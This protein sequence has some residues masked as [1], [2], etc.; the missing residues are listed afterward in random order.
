MK[1]LMVAPEP[2]FE[3]RGTPFSVVGR[4]KTLSD[5][6]YDI[7][8]V[9]YP[10][11]EEISFP[12]LNINRVSHIPGVKKIKI[13]PSL[14][15][16]PFDFLLMMKTFWKLMTRKYDLLHTHEEAGFWGVIFAKW[17]RVPHLYD[18][19]SSLPQ[20]LTNFKFTKSKFWIGL[21][22]FM[23]KWV[24]KD[25]AGVITICPDL[26][27]YVNK[28]TPETKSV[29]IENVID[30][31]M[32]FGSVDHSEMIKETY[33]LEGKTVFLYTG[34]FEPYQGLDLLL[35][36]A[37]HVVPHVREPRFLI[38][39]GHPDQVVE[40]EKKI[41]EAHLEKYFILTGQVPPQEVESYI[42]CADML[43]SPRTSGTNTPLKVYS[44]LRSGV[45]IV[46]TDLWTHTQVFNQDVSILTEPVP[47][48]F[49]EG[50]LEVQKN[51][52]RMK[53]LSNNAKA[54]ADEKYS[55]EVYI[56]KLD[57]IVKT[58]MGVNK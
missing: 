43:L 22:E 49:A 32:I 17:F 50:M 45:P 13:G 30:Y 40:Y 20:Q 31:G 51:P 23:E 28:L 33:A 19:H 37:A 46:A 35:K 29:L 41:Q 38:V 55:Y 34:T 4:L 3:P 56:Q 48:A 25:A 2:I 8:L 21:F 54:L 53:Q 24:L 36:S 27:N 14:I 18:M 52:K 9:T 5:L 44:Y 58:A 39:G 6:D 10:F 16:I 1:I 47:E 7:D 42:K 12:K 11:G 57:A 15:K 26:Q